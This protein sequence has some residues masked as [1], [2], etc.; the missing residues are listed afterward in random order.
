MVSSHCSISGLTAVKGR[1]QRGK[2]GSSI[3]L[4][5]E[6]V[7]PFAQRPQVL[8]STLEIP[9]TLQRLIISR[10]QGI[11]PP[12]V[13]YTA[14]R[15]PAPVWGAATV[16]LSEIFTTSCINAGN[17]KH[18]SFKISQY[19]WLLAKKNGALLS[20]QPTYFSTRLVNRLQS[21]TNILKF[22]TTYF[23][24]ELWQKKYYFQVC[25]KIR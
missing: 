9:Q 18:F 17:F 4:V 24:I 8:T 20:G 12:Q 13:L 10:Q 15:W 6:A 19:Y 25:R 21:S 7:S 22:I 2:S 1:S 23:S 14:N 5:S 3:F 16:V 11:L